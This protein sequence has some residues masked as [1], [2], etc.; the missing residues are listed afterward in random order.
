MSETNIAPKPEKKPIIFSGIQ[1]SGTLT[2][3]NY[4]GAL[5]N[6]SKLQDDYDCIYSIVDMHAITGRIR[7]ICAAA[8][9]SLPLSTS[10][11]ASTP[12]RA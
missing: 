9:W 8:A 6:F 3:G 5:R 4:I 2:L 10:P 1:P 12:R 11:A 7:R